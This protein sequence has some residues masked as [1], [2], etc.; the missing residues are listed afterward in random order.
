MARPRNYWIAIAVCLAL[1]AAIWA[2]AKVWNERAEPV[3]KSWYYEI[4]VD[5]TFDGQPVHIQR[6]AE[7]RPIWRD[8]SGLQDTLSFY[9]A[10]YLAST[11][12]PDGSGIMVVYPAVCRR[13]TPVQLGYDPLILWA[14]NI[15]DPK[16]I[17]AYYHSAALKKDG[18]RIKLVSITVTTPVN[19]APTPYDD[20]FMDWNGGA[21]RQPTPSGTL[22]RFSAAYAFEVPRSAWSS[23]D[24]I[25][26]SLEEIKDDGAIDHKNPLMGWASFAFPLPTDRPLIDS[27]FYPSPDHPSLEDAMESKPLRM[28]DVIPLRIVGDHLEADFGAKGTL[29]FYSRDRL[30]P[31]TTGD[32]PKNAVLVGHKVSGNLGAGSYIWLPNEERLFLLTD[33][34]MDFVLH[35]ESN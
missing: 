9:P 4:A 33:S 2:G 28:R 8:A 17:E 22:L 35:P 7:C 21:G 3:A 16:T 26:S 34:S 25:R 32:G 29:V 18:G 24:R 6:V 12:L 30:M 15:E 27:G 19:A 5:L 1:A 31:Y 11:R 10:R 20:E 13:N 14:D 23:D